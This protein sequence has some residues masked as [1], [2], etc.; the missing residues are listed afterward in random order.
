MTS[1]TTG[2]ENQ[3]QAILNILQSALA[4]LGSSKA[5][6]NGS[7]NST[8]PSH[9]IHQSKKLVLAAVGKLTELVHDPS[10]RL[11][12]VSSQYWE[13]RCLFIAAERRIPDLLSASGANGVSSKDISIATGI[14]ERKLGIH[15]LLKLLKTFSILRRYLL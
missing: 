12:E 9:D 14:E 4:T 7:E 10:S 15:L 5:N 6:V 2:N 1:Q 13:S 8:L 3:L 11:L